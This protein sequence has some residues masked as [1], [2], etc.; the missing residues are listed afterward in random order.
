M[1]KSAREADQARRNGV[2]NRKKRFSFRH[3]YGTNKRSRDRFVLGTRASAAAFTVIRR[4]VRNRRRTN[5]RN[6][7]RLFVGFLSPRRFIIRRFVTVTQGRRSETSYETLRRIADYL[8]SAVLNSHSKTP[9]CTRRSTDFYSTRL[10]SEWKETRLDKSIYIRASQ[11][12]N[13]STLIFVNSLISL[14][15]LVMNVRS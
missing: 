12:S 8:S 11:K 15:E 3:R 13:R 9:S 6:K 5:Q 10:L 14:H 7:G 1:T 4:T 2:E